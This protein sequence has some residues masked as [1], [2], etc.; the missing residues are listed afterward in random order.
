[1]KHKFSYFF[2]VIALASALPT[3]ALAQSNSFDGFYAGVGAGYAWQDI[4]STVQ[5]V[6]RGVP[7]SENYGQSAS[8][9]LGFGQLFIGYGLSRD[10]VYFGTEVGFNLYQEGNNYNL[11]NLYNLAPPSPPHANSMTNKI[12]PK[13]GFQLSF[14][15]G[16]Y[17][18]PD[19]L[20]YGRLGGAVTRYDTETKTDVNLPGFF[21]T[22]NSD[23][24]WVPELVVG[25]GLAQKMWENISVRV[26]YTYTYS[27][28]F[29]GAANGYAD[30][31]NPSTNFIEKNEDIHIKSNNL[32]F[33]L[34]YSF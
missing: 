2:K 34:V 32:A 21:A 1:M 9:E 26:D 31:T 25:A 6:E 13:Y 7:Y 18:T 4:N 14:L 30:T 15:P 28:D 12:S 16:L 20:I 23:S 11:K 5:P 33:S 29:N 27:A 19:T 3:V 24:N 22:N 8:Q 17:L 10:I